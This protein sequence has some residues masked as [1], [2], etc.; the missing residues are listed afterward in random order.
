VWTARHIDCDHSE[1]YKVNC[2]IVVSSTIA[3]YSGSL[4]CSG[5]HVLHVSTILPDKGVLMSNRRRRE[6]DV[7]PGPIS[8]TRG[9][10]V[11]PGP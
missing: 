8:P 10:A 11:N 2:L 7:G 4:H 6:A 5:D 1:L 9:A 3:M